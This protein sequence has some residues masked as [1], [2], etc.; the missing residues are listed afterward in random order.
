MQTKAQK[1]KIAARYQTGFDNILLSPW[2][3]V[4]I[5][6]DVIPYYLPKNST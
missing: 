4:I 2:D 6:L 3:T 1:L 5:S